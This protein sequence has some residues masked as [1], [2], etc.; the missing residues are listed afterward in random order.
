[1]NFLQK[2]RWW[3]TSH[4]WPWSEIWRLRED[5]R[6]VRSNLKVYLDEKAQHRSKWMAMA[7]GYRSSE[8]FTEGELGFMSHLYDEGYGWNEAVNLLNSRGAQKNVFM[9]VKRG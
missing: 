6:F 1:M 9:E 7:N 3:V 8:P 5:L 2:I 4:I